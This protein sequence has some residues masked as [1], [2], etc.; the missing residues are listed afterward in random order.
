MDEYSLSLGDAGA[1]AHAR[2]RIGAHQPFDLG[3]MRNPAKLGPPPRG[4]CRPAPTASCA[5]QGRYEISRRKRVGGP[6]RTSPLSPAMK[7]T[8]SLAITVSS[9]CAC[10]TAQI[11]WGDGCGVCISAV[12][13]RSAGRR[14]D[15]SRVRRHG[16]ST[17][18][19]DFRSPAPNGGADQ[20]G[21]IASAYRRRVCPRCDAVVRH[22]VA[23]QL[24]LVIEPNCVCGLSA[25]IA[26]PK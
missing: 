25:V 20:S 11:L 26:A 4:K 7:P 8:D 23:V 5:G 18:L 22:E 14:C 12:C 24:A 13:L 15:R 10:A 2:E 3:E 6:R 16:P 17:A 9:R 19:R 1:G 21:L